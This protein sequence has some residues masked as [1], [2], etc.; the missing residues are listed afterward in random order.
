MR[1]RLMPYKIGSEGAKALSEGLNCLR[2]YN[3]ASTRYK[4]RSG[5]V[6]I[7]WGCSTIRTINCARGTILS[8]V[9]I[10]NKPSAVAIACNKLQTLVQLHHKNVGAPQFTTQRETALEWIHNLG[11][12]VYARNV[13]TGSCGAGI[14]IC[15]SNTDVP[16]AP[17]YT[18]A[19][20]AKREYR[21]HVV[22]NTV[23]DFCKKGKRRDREQDPNPMIRNHENGWIFIRDGVTLPEEIEAESIKATK[24]LG[25]DFGAVDIGWRDGDVCVYEINSA[26]GFAS[27]STTSIRYT[28]ALQEMIQHV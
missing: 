22:G 18:R 4:A 9:R 2:V 28:Q 19:F 3:S 8:D 25:L 13:L 24:A 5:D 7:N 27:N 20:N 15:N 23:I 6:I 17:L 14:I 26:P 10:L 12:T 1:I 21:V 16:C 11:A